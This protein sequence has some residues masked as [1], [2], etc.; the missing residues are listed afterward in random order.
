VSRSPRDVFEHPR[1]RGTGRLRAVDA[2]AEGHGGNGLDTEAAPVGYGE[3]EWHQWAQKNRQGNLLNNLN[4]AILALESDPAFSGM[5]AHDEMARQFFALASKARGVPP[6]QLRS[7]Q[8]AIYM[9]KR[10][11][12]GRMLDQIRLLERPVAASEHGEAVVL[13]VGVLGCPDARLVRIVDVVVT[14]EDA[15]ALPAEADLSAKLQ[16]APVTGGPFGEVD[17]LRLAGDWPVNVSG[18]FPSHRGCP[19]RPVPQ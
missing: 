17:D 9:G 11:K 14:P 10:A 7:L 5:F 19:A 3:P 1:K 6:T 15:D 8:A 2:P 16:A 18:H 12:A 13:V 4:N